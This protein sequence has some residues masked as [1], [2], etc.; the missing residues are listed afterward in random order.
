[1]ATLLIDEGTLNKGDVVVVS[2]AYGKV[3]TMFDHE[4]KTIDKVPPGRPV[5]VQGL[6]EVP[7][8]GDAFYVVKNE[9]EAK[10]IVGHRLEELRASRSGQTA[11]LNLEDFYEKLQG[12]EK[13]ELKVV[14]KA[15]VQGSA[16]AVKQA[17]EKLSTDKVG[18][19]VIHHGVGAINETDVNLASA[20]KAMMVGF[21]T[22]PDT[23]AKKLA[24]SLGVEIH[25]HKVIYDLTEDINSAQVG[26]LP[27]KVKETVLGRA[28][29]RE[30]FNVPKVG[31]VAGVSVTDGKMVRGAMVRLVRDSV[32][33]HQG[34]MSSLRRFKEDVR[35]VASGY[36]CGI[37]LEN[38][39]DIKRGDVIE[40]FELE[41]EQPTL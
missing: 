9:R 10:K 15:D 41:E 21:N 22:R 13:L 7:M 12:T 39:N 17:L 34:K 31:T 33:V 16:E 20:S 30:L 25:L 35:E 40:A 27:S 26:L 1:V 29:V 5:Q 37:G 38:Y 19:K 36:E 4:G 11:R 18:V 24:Q 23:N 32:E 14:V 28:E 2:T 8:A 3:R 6:N